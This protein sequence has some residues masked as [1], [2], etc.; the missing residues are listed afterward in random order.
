MPFS[1]FA[2]LGLTSQTT[3][4]S[5]GVQ[6]G[7]RRVAITPPSMLRRCHPRW[8]RP[9]AVYAGVL[10]LL[11][12]A[13]LVVRPWRA[14]NSSSATTSS[15]SSETATAV[16]GR[17]V[18]TDHT[19]VVQLH[20]RRVRRVEDVTSDTAESRIAAATG[21]WPTFAPAGLEGG[22]GGRAS[23][24]RASASPVGAAAAAGVSAAG[25]KLSP[26]TFADEP[27]P[28]ELGD[29]PGRTD[30]YGVQWS[31]FIRVRR[32]GS[33]GDNNFDLVPIHR[34]KIAKVPAVWAAPLVSSGKPKLLLLFHGCNHGA[35]SFYRFGEHRAFM[36]TALSGGWTVLALSSADRTG[37]RCWDSRDLSENVDLARVH[38]AITIFIE[39]H[40]LKGAMISAMGASSGGHFVTLMAQARQLPLNAIALY[41]SPGNRRILREVDADWPPTVF[42][43]MPRDTGAATIIRRNVE[44][45]QIKGVP[46]TAV[47]CAERPVTTQ[48]FV[49]LL[50]VTDE[51][52]QH[53]INVLV[54]SGVVAQDGTVMVDGRQGRRVWQ[55]S[56]EGQSALAQELYPLTRE[57]SEI[58]NSHYAMHEMT[59][60]HAAA[61]VAWL[62][63]PKEVAKA[64]VNAIP[65]NAAAAAA[66]AADDDEA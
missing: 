59:S 38:A 15:S 16:S 39:A 48:T 36:S 66:A 35:D 11:A 2:A 3:E 18:G 44:I 46:A 7:V 28:A 31:E 25:S 4:F 51:V 26:Q 61:V 47:E 5:G 27:Y 13:G 10:L 57:I 54:E 40:N 64:S 52:A 63:R 8:W 37:S 20:S 6:R 1:R 58:L 60:Y 53:A 41:V 29:A 12:I 23:A 56:L 50:A 17:D 55:R 33:N 62:G 14:D 9:T 24:G 65:G 21:F 42:V 22:G 45:L 49:R 43:H 32:A 19:P 30:R 34:D